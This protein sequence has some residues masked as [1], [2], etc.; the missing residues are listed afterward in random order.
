[1]RTRPIMLSALLVTASACFHCGQTPTAEPASGAASA[2]AIAP[3]QRSQPAAS[4]PKEPAASVAKPRA[5]KGLSAQ[6]V[7]QD[8]YRFDPRLADPGTR[9]ALDALWTPL[10]DDY[11]P[12]ASDRPFEALY[13]R[14]TDR[15][16]Q[17]MPDKVSPQDIADIAG[18]IPQ[19]QA[20]DQAN[21]DAATRYRAHFG[22]QPR[23][24]VLPPPNVTLRLRLHNH[25]DEPIHVK[26]NGDATTRR[27]RLVGPGA[28]H[29]L[30][31]GDMTEI[32]MCGTW[33]TIAP[34]G[35]YELPVSDLSYGQR[36]ADLGAY[37]TQPGRYQLS[38]SFV[39]N[40]ARGPVPDDC[41]GGDR[42]EITAPAMTI[43]V[44]G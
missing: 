10:V 15:Y 13:R 16:P 39:T 23:Q 7:G 28:K 31:G 12:Q 6:L 11:A 40:M 33:V 44:G 29:A 43:D 21:H 38:M 17:G 42:I 25:S 4:A 36:S 35:D 2:T 3:I 37:W 9:A 1:M 19:M 34:H 5:N 27:M 32:Y 18:V 30:G 22:D 41:G 26:L 8:H 14:M 20:R 24:L